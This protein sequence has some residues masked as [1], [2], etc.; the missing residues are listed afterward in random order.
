MISPLVNFFFNLR[1]K[2]HHQSHR[3]YTHAPVYRKIFLDVDEKKL[4]SL[5]GQGALH[6]FLFKFWICH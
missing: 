6:S 4:E 3:F 2:M 1:H 5:K